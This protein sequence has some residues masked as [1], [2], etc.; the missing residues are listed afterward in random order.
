MSNIA[1]TRILLN[2]IRIK[3][4]KQ[5][6]TESVKILSAF[7][8]DPSSRESQYKILLRN[9]HSLMDFSEENLDTSL[10]LTQMF[11]VDV[12][13]VLFVWLDSLKDGLVLKSLSI[14][15]NFFGKIV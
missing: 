4:L 6:Y 8:N 12:N 10:R 11:N 3:N 14:L 2:N 13:C 9:N 7:N 15:I 1:T 5:P